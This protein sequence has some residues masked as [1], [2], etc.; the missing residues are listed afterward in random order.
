MKE[1]EP[2]KS[3]A[4]QLVEELGWE[5]HEDGIS[6]FTT[7]PNEKTAQEYAE[8]VAKWEKENQKRKDK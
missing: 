3:M 7:E 5:K 2:K 6:Y 1:Q 8:S 4:E